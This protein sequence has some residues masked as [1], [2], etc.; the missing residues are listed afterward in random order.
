MGLR[1]RKSIKIAPGV[2][3]NIGLKSVGISVGGKHAG[4]S[5]NSK[6]GATARVSAGHGTG[7]SYVTKIGG[8]KKN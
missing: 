8:G 7:L 1:F 5:I 6:T 3:L 4:I 2:K